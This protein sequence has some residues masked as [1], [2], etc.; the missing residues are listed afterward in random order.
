ML[1]KVAG[2]QC[3]ADQRVH[4]DVNGILGLIVPLESL[5][6][7]IM[8]NEL[9]DEIREATISTE[10]AALEFFVFF[11]DL[12]IHVLEVFMLVL[13]VVVLVLDLRTLVFYPIALLSKPPVFFAKIAKLR[14]QVVVSRL[15]LAELLLVFRKDVIEDRGVC[16][17]RIVSKISFARLSAL[18]AVRCRGI[19]AQALV[20]RAALSRSGVLLGAS[21]ESEGLEN[22]IE[23]Y[24][25][26]H[27]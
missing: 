10:E 11:R 18:L 13:N 4:D 22:N 15:L 3:I 26:S 7:R 12:V 6:C 21:H 9:F 24:F 27:C 17:I 19:N 5:C 1:S 2:L 14:L 8:Y 20:M 16:R 25:L 23:K